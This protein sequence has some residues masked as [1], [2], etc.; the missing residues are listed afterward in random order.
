MSF[1]RM[2]QVERGGSVE[3]LGEKVYITIAL[4][5][6]MNV[7]T[8]ACD[9]ILG[10][11]PNAESRGSKVTERGLAQHLK[12]LKTAQLNGEVVEP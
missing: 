5:L 9:G 7:L 1:H 10:I 4:G 8:L 12:Q 6:A 11:F 2:G 3:A